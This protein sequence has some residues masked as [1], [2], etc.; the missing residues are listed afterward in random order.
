MQGFLPALLLL[1]HIWNSDFLLSDRFLYRLGLPLHPLPCH[2]LTQGFLPVLLLLHH[3]WNSDFLL[4]DHCRYRLGLPLH[5]LPCHDLRQEL[6]PEVYKH[7]HNQQHHSWNLQSDLFRY[8]LDL[9]LYQFLLCDL[10]HYNGLLHQLILYCSFQ[11]KFSAMRF[12][13]LHRRH[14]LNCYSP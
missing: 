12:R 7:N 3:I 6:L 11:L 13:S 2:D 9:P 1:H 10:L 14:S 4:S 8:R 5:P